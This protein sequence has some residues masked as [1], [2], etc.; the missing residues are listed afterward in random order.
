VNGGIGDPIDKPKGMRWATVDTKV[1]QIA[2]AEAIYHARLLH[3][4]KMI[5]L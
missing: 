1:E 4:L 5:N 3:L 2:A